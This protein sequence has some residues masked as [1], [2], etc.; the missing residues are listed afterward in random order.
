MKPPPVDRLMERAA[1]CVVPQS[2]SDRYSSPIDALRAPTIV[3][4]LHDVLPDAIC[5]QGPFEG[6]PELCQVLLVL[7]VGSIEEWRHDGT[8]FVRSIAIKG[9]GI[10]KRKAWLARQAR[11]VWPD[12]RWIE[13]VGA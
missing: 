8:T 2:I 6:L 11:E 13:E 1:R 3:P 10:E 5:L 4:D 7:G 12:L 9:D